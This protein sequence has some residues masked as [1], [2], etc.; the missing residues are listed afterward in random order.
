MKLLFTLLLFTTF[1][2]AAIAQKEISIKEE[3]YSYSVGSKNSFLVKIPDS[4]KELVEK[5]LTSEMKSWGGK[6][7]G[8]KGE[9]STIQSAV[10]K[11]F[12]G[13]TFDSYVKVFQSGQDVMVAVAIDLGGA[14]LSSN[15]HPSQFNEMRERLHN[16]AVEAGKASLQ[17]DVKTEEKILS[18]LKKEQKSLEKVRSTE[19]KNIESYKKKIA[20]SEK[21]IEENKSLTDKKKAEIDAQD[22]K[23][24][25]IKKTK[26]K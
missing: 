6:M 11:M 16:F 7:S 25:E 14:F 5:E 9:Y 4:K 18:T 17:S 22:K 20:E 24:S 8:K 23:I 10:K 1:S 12:E 21:K 15:Q 13:K 26:V 3:N 19:E 2:F